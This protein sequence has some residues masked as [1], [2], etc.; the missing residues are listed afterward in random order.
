MPK[1][2][3]RTYVRLQQCDEFIPVDFAISE[4]GRQKARADRLTRVDWDHGPTAV[5][6]TKEVMAALDPSGL[7]SGFPQRRDAATISRPVIRGRRL[8]PR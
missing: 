8:T 1:F 6:V 5:G 7:K 3:A 2:D 4:D